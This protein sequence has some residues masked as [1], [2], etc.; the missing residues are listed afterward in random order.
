MEVIRDSGIPD[1]L[2]ICGGS[3]A[4]ATCHVYIDPDFAAQM[5]TQQAGESDLLDFSEHRTDR[6]RLSCQLRVTESFEGLRVT[7]APEE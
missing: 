6:S 3:C 4:C 7:I 1:I 2:A 5:P